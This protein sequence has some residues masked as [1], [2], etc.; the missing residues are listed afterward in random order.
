MNPTAKILSPVMAREGK[1]GVSYYQQA[2]F[3]CEQFRVQQD[4]YV[5][6]PNA[7]FVPGKTYDWDVAGSLQI[8]QY[9]RIELARRP[10]L[11]ERKA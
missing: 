6:G 9:Q 2:T 10:K 7:G 3:E 8:G 1:N 4:V 5:D 11:I